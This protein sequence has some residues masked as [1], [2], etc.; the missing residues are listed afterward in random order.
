MIGHAKIKTGLVNGEYATD[1]TEH[2]ENRQLDVAKPSPDGE[3]CRPGEEGPDRPWRKRRQTTA[4]T[5]GDEMC[6]MGEKK[7]QRR[8]LTDLDLDQNDRI[9]CV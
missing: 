2:Q 9:L 6:R 8:R 4:E 1:K 5:A 7:A 3:K